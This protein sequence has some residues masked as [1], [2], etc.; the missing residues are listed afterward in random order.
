MDQLLGR[1]LQMNADKRGVS[2]SKMTALV[3]GPGH[4]V[5]YNPIVAVDSVHFF[6]VCV[7]TVCWDKGLRDQIF[8]TSR[9]CCFIGHHLIMETWPLGLCCEPTSLLAMACTD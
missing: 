6:Y 7:Q 8:V 1:V 3:Q 9:G 5:L 2:A 4:A